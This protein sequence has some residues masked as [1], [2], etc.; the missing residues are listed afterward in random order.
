MSVIIIIVAAIFV[1]WTMYVL[2][3][4]NRRKTTN[5]TFRSTDKPKLS[6]DINKV[7]QDIEHLL[8]TKGLTEKSNIMF[9]KH[10]AE[11]L[12]FDE[13]LRI[14][15]GTNDVFKKKDA[16][17]SMNV[18]EFGQAVV[19]QVKKVISSYEKYFISESPEKL[20]YHIR[21]LMVGYSISADNAWVA[22]EKLVEKLI[23]DGLTNGK[24]IIEF[25]I[26]QLEKLAEE[27]EIK[28]KLKDIEW[29]ISE[30]LSP[31]LR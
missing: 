10:K 11:K 6:K 20:P 23:Q 12:F 14:L 26:R 7:V 16:L 1:V 24:D 28:N 4:N 27:N 3:K 13:V 25:K 19:S 5:L 30:R 29:H 22:I 9:L 21:V 2:S 8:V 15:A 31:E 18:E 17:L